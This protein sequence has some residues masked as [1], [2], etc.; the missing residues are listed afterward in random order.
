MRGPGRPPHLEAPARV[1]DAADAGGRRR[2][3]GS[4]GAGDDPGARNEADAVAEASVAPLCVEGSM[5]DRAP[6]EVPAA[7][8]RERVDA[9]VFCSHRDAARRHAR[10]RLRASRQDEARVEAAEVGEA[11]QEAEHRDLVV[12]LRVQGDDAPRSERPVALAMCGRSSPS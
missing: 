4:F 3:P 1:V 6:E 2:C 10:A 12:A 8:R 7:G 5:T 11:G 9:R